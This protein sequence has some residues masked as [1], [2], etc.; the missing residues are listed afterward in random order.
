MTSENP[1][2]HQKVR[3]ALSLST[4]PPHTTSIDDAAPFEPLKLIAVIRQIASPFPNCA[5]TILTRYLC[6]E[7]TTTGP[8]DAFFSRA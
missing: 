5:V 2:M 1:Q 4:S 8:E 6:L 7:T 3:L